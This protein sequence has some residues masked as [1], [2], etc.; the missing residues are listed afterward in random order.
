MLEWCL[1]ALN[2]RDPSHGWLAQILGFM[3]GKAMSL[4]NLSTGLLILP[5]A[6]S[7]L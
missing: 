4:L 3:L 5:A 1:N 6:L 7:A 2:W